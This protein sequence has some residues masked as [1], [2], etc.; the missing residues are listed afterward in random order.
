[1]N[2]LEVE[3]APQEFDD[4]T[5]AEKICAMVRFQYYK[6]D[7]KY[8][9][10]AIGQG[11]HVVSVTTYEL[12]SKKKMSGKIRM[13]TGIDIPKM[14]RVEYNEFVQAVMDASTDIDIKPRRFDSLGNGL[15]TRRSDG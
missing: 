14:T 7:G 4:A 15:Y 6:V 11:G 2:N 8:H 3:N 13:L 9:Y 10:R 5:F 1:M 12:L